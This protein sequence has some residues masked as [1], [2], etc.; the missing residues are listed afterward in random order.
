[1]TDEK[2]EL[3]GLEVAHAIHVGDKEVAFVLH[4]ESE[5]CPYL[6]CYN[7]RTPELGLDNPSG[8]VGF[9]DYLD[10]MEE[11]LQR[12]QGQVAQVRAERNRTNE[13]Q[14]VLGREHCLPSDGTEPDLH[15]RVVVIRPDALRPEYRNAAQQ[16]V[17]V[18]GGFGAAPNAR[19][20]AVF[21]TNVFSG[22][23]SDWRR[24][25]VLGILDPAKAPAWVKPGVA[26]IREQAKPQ[27]KKKGGKP[28]ELS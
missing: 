17:F 2:R 15:G 28:H 19:G 11:F 1:M 6:V 5:G 23:K 3:G 18:T 22:E 8:L 21:G 16:T 13:P 24:E 10:A 14:E 7:S 25:D 20:R 26:A 9:T 12:V 4:P 27:P